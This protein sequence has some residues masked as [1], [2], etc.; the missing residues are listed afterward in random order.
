MSTEGLPVKFVAD[1]TVVLVVGDKRE[2]LRRPKMAE[3]RRF[4]E[5]EE[6]MN[7]ALLELADEIGVEES[8][9]EDELT[10]LTGLEGDERDKLLRN[11]RKASDLSA[12]L[13]DSGRA[14][15]RRLAKQRRELVQRLNA[16]TEDLRL[17][18]LRLVLDTL[19]DREGILSDDSVEQWMVEQSFTAAL[20]QHW[21][22]VPLPSGA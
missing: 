2:R 6:D 20:V 7:D 17:S 22:T 16:G 1:G 10:A 13:G 14:E 15:V 12:D 21:R 9:L 4:R 11:P 19:G 8:A 5:A 18:W 3:M